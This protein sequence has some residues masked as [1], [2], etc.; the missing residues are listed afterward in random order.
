MPDESLKAAER[1][2]KL[3]AA[4]CDLANSASNP[5]LLPKSSRSFGRHGL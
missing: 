1:Y 3:A 4:F 2:R 5:F